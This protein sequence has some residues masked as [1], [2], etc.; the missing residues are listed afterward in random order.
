MVY[1]L[2]VRVSY[3]M[4]EHVIIVL[5]EWLNF[6]TKQGDK[7][8]SFENRLEKEIRFRERKS[9][10]DFDAPDA[11]C[12]RLAMRKMVELMIK[13]H[14]IQTCSCLFVRQCAIYT[15]LLRL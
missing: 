15:T 7:L 1:F 8:S 10:T 9:S 13:W 4:M 2:H 12:N 3:K 11:V 6:D 5:S 14:F